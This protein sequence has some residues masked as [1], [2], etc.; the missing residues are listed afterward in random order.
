M[1]STRDEIG[2][3]RASAGTWPQL[4]DLSSIASDDKGFAAGDAIKDLS[5]MVAQLSNGDRIH[6]ENVSP[7]RPT[8]RGELG[9]VSIR[10]LT[11]T[12][13]GLRDEVQP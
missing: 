4:G 5:P 7:V 10:I 2:W 9:I 1:A 8:W 11:V 13:S 3:R 6:K 12:G